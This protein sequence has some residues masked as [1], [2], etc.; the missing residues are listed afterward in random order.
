VPRLRLLL[1]ALSVSR[2][3]AA[4][5]SAAELTRSIR[6]MG[7]DPAACYRVRD[8]SFAREDIRLYLTDG[9][10]IFSKPVMG[11]RL[12]AVFT[13]DVEN[14]DGEIIL[15]PPTRGERQSMASFTQSPNLDE[16]LRSALLISTD[17]SAA[18]LLE[19]MQ[20]ED[21]GKP[22]PEMGAI[23][24]NQWSPVVSNIGAAMEMRVIEDLASSRPQ[25]RGLLFLAIGGKMLGNFDIVA[26]SATDGRIAVRQRT[27]R[28]GT[29]GYNLWTSFFS[30][31][32]RNATQPKFEPDFKLSR[33]RIDAAIGADLAVKAVTRVVLR[34]GANPA[35]AFLFAIARAM[36]VKSVRIDGQPVELL[37]GDSKRG[38]I[39]GND[40]EEPFLVLAPEPLAAGSEHEFEFEHEGNVI[41]TQGDGVYF[42]NARGSWYPH[43]GSG[44][45]DFDL[46]FR[47]P[48]RL[49]LVTSGDPVEDRVEG[50]WR[51]THR[52]TSIPVGAAGFNL[53]DYEKVAGTAAG[54]SFEVYGNRHLIE[55]LR[56][57]TLFIPPPVPAMGIRRRRPNPEPL[58]AEVAP[59]APDPLARLRA[60]AADVSSSLEFYSGLFG[61]PA[62]KTLTVAPIPGTFGQG[63]PGLVYLSTF[64]YLDPAERPAALRTARQ[65]VFFSDLITAHEVAHQWWG[66]VVTSGSFDDDWLVEA[67]AN[68]SAL[69]WLEKKKGPKAL[70]SVLDGYRE[71]LLKKDTGG[72]V[73]E[74]VGPIVWGG[75]LRASGTADDWI[76]ITYGKGAWILHM[77][78]RRIGDERFRQML[79][80]LRHRYEFRPVTIR[81][82]R[83]LA[84][85]FRPARTSAEVIDTFFDNWVDATGVPSLKLRYSVNGVAPAVKLSGAVAQT[86]VDDDFSMD[87]PVEVQFAKGAPQIIWV[88][89]SE[90]EQPF[91]VT[92]RQAPVRVAIPNDVL[93]KK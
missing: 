67:L 51:I 10:L 13:A 5:P 20:K 21:A 70:E 88:R 93:M 6:E 66:S 59:L 84:R 50:D 83:M 79:A 31:S 54:I 39:A 38:R 48:K 8:L 29:F 14:G 3:F 69:M 26:D 28:D 7:L 78:R 81:E 46:T 58:G 73:V 23:L 62:L 57:R 82:F 64:A 76:V 24:S 16:H 22:A 25:G 85:E 56:P 89:T 55:A 49:T 68:Y 15:I 37:V 40:L 47:Y 2:V 44:F 18:A 43:V 91:S 60:V 12:A 11:R 65:E 4:S 90:D 41:V 63:F 42:V 75:R 80:E 53:G 45:A 92:L 71:A 33:Y 87:V 19:R 32:V 72:N 61:P 52:R 74:S 77:L 34:T 86:G 17:G 27:E 30:R 36:Q 9:Y 35:R 1:V